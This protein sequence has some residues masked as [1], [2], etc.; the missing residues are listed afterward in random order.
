[1]KLVMINDCAYVGETLLRYMPKDLE[2]H[3]IKRNRNLWNKTFGL[4]LKIMKTK[5]DVFHV[6]YL[7]QDCYIATKLRKKPLLGHAHGS[8]LR[9][10]IKNRKW[11]WMIK[12]NLKK[13]D[14]IIVAQPTILDEALR[15]NDTSEYFPI[16]YD[17]QLFFPKSTH[18]DRKQ[19]HVFIASTHNFKTKGT[20]KLLKALAYFSDSVTITSIASGKNLKEAINLAKKLNLQIVFIPKVSHSKINKLYWESDFVLGSFGIGQLDTVAIEAM[21]CGRPVVHSISKKHF[22]TCPLEQIETVN[23]MTEIIHKL[24]FE[25]REREQRI[26]NQLSYVESTHSAPIL[27]KKLFE[28]YTKL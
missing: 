13:C 10:Q 7:L 21:A 4:A 14:K 20:N 17:P 18:K 22:R 27:S 9:E 2:K 19:K 28:I 16:P 24:L 8:D 6:N 5:G 3:H 11:G 26:K 12:K 1:M 25:K 15:F 23:G